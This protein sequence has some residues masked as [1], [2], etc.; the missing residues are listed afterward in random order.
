MR[1]LRRWRQALVG[2]WSRSPGDGGSPYGAERGLW[3]RLGAGSSILEAPQASTPRN[4]GLTTVFRV[5]WH[6][7]AGADRSSYEGPT[8]AK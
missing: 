1:G 7:T 5:R 6:C 4:K 3:E 8:L 2:V